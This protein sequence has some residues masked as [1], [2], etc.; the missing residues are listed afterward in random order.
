MSI[1]SRLVWTYAR[2]GVLVETFHVEC[3]VDGKDETFEGLFFRILDD[4][5]DF[6][7][8]ALGN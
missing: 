2:P 1:M 4:Y 8:I 7:Y 5:D 3:T 6:I